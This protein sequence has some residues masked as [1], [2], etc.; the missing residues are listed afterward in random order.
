VHFVSPCRIRMHSS[1]SRACSSSTHLLQ[2]A[3]HRR[4]K[5]G[6][7]RGKAVF[8][9]ALPCIHACLPM[10]PPGAVPPSCARLL[11]LA[12]LLQVWPGTQGVRR[13]GTHREHM[14]EP[15]WRGEVAA[16]SSHTLC[17]CPHPHAAC[18]SPSGFRAC[19]SAPSPSS[20]SSLPLLLTTGA[21]RRVDARI[22][23]RD[24]GFR[25]SGFP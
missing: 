12:H 25:R 1:S 16:V 5:R 21:H 14:Q 18:R 17:R 24:A 11:A 9:L 19:R 3:G 22:T 20:S 15:S 4:H 10:F 6:V 13:D 8:P 2:Q 7:R 23:G